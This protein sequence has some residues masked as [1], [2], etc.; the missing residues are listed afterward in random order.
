VMHVADV[1]AGKDLPIIDANNGGSGVEFPETLTKA[2][3]LADGRADTI[4]TGHDGLVT[5]AD[6]REFAAFNRDFLNAARAA[7]QAGKT[8]EQAAAEWTTPA[9]YAGYA[10]PQAARTRT[11]MQVIFDELR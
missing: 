2:A 1:F 11:N 6:L 3:A 10:A 8:A 4:I 9:R 7:R 5:V